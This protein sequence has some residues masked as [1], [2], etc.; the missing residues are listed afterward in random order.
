[1]MTPLSQGC[2]M[3]PFRWARKFDQCSFL[4]SQFSPEEALFCDDTR[5]HIRFFISRKAFFA[6]L[7][8][9]Q[10][11]SELAR[12][13]LANCS[14]QNSPEATLRSPSA[15]NSDTASISAA[16]NQVRG[17]QDRARRLRS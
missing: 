6:E 9:L 11:G 7:A 4:D 16:A 13:M 17:L 14:S 5:G 15:T 12:A 1:M 2:M 10:F 3:G 8:Q